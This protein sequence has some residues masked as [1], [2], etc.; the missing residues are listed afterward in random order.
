MANRKTVSVKESLELLRRHEAVKVT[1]KRLE[2]TCKV[3]AAY[4][5]EQSQKHGSKTKS[6]ICSQDHA[7]QSQQGAHKDKPCWWCGGEQHVRNI[8]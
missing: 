2:K 4:S 8:W 6:Q 7:K 3:S 1:M 5:R